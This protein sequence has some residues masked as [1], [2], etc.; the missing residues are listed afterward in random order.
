MP[1]YSVRLT[2]VSKIYKSESVEVDAL[3]DVSFTLKSGEF[4][5]IVGP[6]GSGKSTLMNV[7]GTIDKP[8][9]GE[10]YIDGVA[11]SK[12][13][14]DKLAEFRNKKLGFIFQ[15]YNL[16]NGLTAEMNVQLPLMVS[17]MPSSERKERSDSL[18]IQLGLGER[19]RQKPNQLS[20]GQQQRVAIARALVNN[21]ALVL[22]D[23]PTGNLDTK[24]GEEVVRLFKKISRERKVTIIMVTHNPD[25]TRFCDRVI[26]IKDGRVNKNEVIR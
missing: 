16:V 11:T 3:I 23:E 26:H 2:N 5:A 25:I 24:S 15:A 12:M 17:K 13:D 1:N 4:V 7:L 10:I 19:M 21:P 9:H 14:G 20:G 22:A 8:T 18:L 6:S